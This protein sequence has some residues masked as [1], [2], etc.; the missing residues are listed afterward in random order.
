MSPQFWMPDKCKMNLNCFPCWAFFFKHGN[1]A[2]HIIYMGFSGSSHLDSL[3]HTVTDWSRAIHVSFVSYAP[4]GNRSSSS[5]NFF[6]TARNSSCG[7][8]LFSHVS[9]ILLTGCGMGLGYF[10]CQVPSSS[11]LVL[12]GGRGGRVSLD[13]CSFLWAGG[14]VSLVPCPWGW[15]VG[16]PGGRVYLRIPYTP[17][18][19]K[20][21]VRI[22]LECF[23][24]VCLSFAAAMW[25]PPPVAFSR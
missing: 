19:P 12:Y 6:F 7:K 22:L 14:R 8:V 21:T 20:R 11:L 16:Y 13:L 5:G 3:H 18:L 4:I 10:W 2:H 23:L 9:I 24:V 1:E 17:E 15:G 25:P